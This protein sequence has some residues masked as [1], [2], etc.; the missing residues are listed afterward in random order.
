MT[1]TSLYQDTLVP[2]EDLYQDTLVGELTGNNNAMIRSGVSSDIDLVNQYFMHHG[3]DDV[4]Q[5]L[6]NMAAKESN[7]G[8][9]KMGDYS[10]SPFQ[11]DAIKYLDIQ[12]DAE[13]PKGNAAKRA[14]LANTFLRQQLGD[15]NFDILNMF[16]GE[17]TEEGIRYIPNER[18]REHSPLI[19][20][21]LARL[22]LGNIPTEKDDQGNPIR[23][24][25]MSL[26]QQGDYWKRHW[27]TLSGKGT[28]DEFVKAAQY[29]FPNN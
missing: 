15:P 28:A 22:G 12:Q 10:Y 20:A 25:D 18:L 3:M 19:G 9:D 21:T 24:S 2:N 7:V 17:S 11:I 16:E 23:I 5:F 6:K 13:N 27:N 26:E 4:G 14:Q 8:T 1:E 29:H